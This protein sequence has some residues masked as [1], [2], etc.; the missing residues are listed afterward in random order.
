MNLWISVGRGIITRGRM[1][2]RSEGSHLKERIQLGRAHEGNETLWNF[3]PIAG[4]VVREGTKFAVLQIVIHDHPA[5]RE[6]STCIAT[7]N[8]PLAKSGYAPAIYSQ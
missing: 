4:F 6:T 8:S 2:T 3:E 7:I 1:R 5:Q